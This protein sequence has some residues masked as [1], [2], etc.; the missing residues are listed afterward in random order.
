MMKMFSGP[1]IKPGSA[2][3]DA[4]FSRDTRI[5]GPKDHLVHGRLK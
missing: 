1:H 5:Y 2:S 4:V 3:A